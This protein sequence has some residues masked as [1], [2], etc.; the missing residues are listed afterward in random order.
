V[1]EDDKKLLRKAHLAGA[2]CSLLVI[3]VQA[4]VMSVP[5]IRDS[6]FRLWGMR[7]FAENSKLEMIMGDPFWGSFTIFLTVISVILL[8]LFTYINYRITRPPRIFF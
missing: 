6:W 1:R 4:V 2:G 7:S 3:A 8:L 5:G